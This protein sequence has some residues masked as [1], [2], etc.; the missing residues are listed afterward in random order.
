MVCEIW[1]SKHVFQK[2]ISCFEAIL[3]Q[4]YC[5]KICSQK[6]IFGVF[7][8][9]KF[10]PHKYMY[11]KMIYFSFPF[12]RLCYHLK[13][14]FSNSMDFMVFI[15]SM[16]WMKVLEKARVQSQQKNLALVIKKWL[17]YTN[18]SLRALFFSEILKISIQFHNCS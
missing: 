14:K 15:L 18:P 4:L 12:L 5:R 1:C 10:F 8:A 17:F 3:H 2:I 16:M 9:I 6:N 7:C 13:I 11:T